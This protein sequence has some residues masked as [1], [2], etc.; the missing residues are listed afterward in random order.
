MRPG[1]ITMDQRKISE[2]TKNG[3]HRKDLGDLSQLAKS[4]EE[5]GLLHPVVIRADNVLIAGERRLEACKLLGWQKVP[6]RIV[7]LQ[8]IV[9]G[10]YDENTMRK[11]FTNSEAFAIYAE[12]KPLMQAEAK[13]RQ[14]ATQFGGNGGGNFPPPDKGKTRDKA[15]AGVGRSG[16]TMEKIETIVYAAEEM[17]LPELVEIMDN[18]SVEAAYK[19]LEKAKKKKERSE[20]AK[21]AKD[22]RPSDRWHVYNSDMQTWTSERQYDFI[23]TDPPYPREFLYLYESL[24]IRANEWLKDGGLLIAMCGQSYLD[25]IYAMMSRHIDYYWTAAYLTPG[26][27]TPLRQVN[28][29]TT[30][31]PLLI[32]SKGKYEGKIFGDV[33]RSDRNDKEFHEW[34]QSVSGMY[35]IVSKVCLPGQYILDPFCG[36]GTTGVAALK[37]E[38]FFDGVELNKENVEIS[39]ARLGDEL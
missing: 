23:V 28:V 27:P 30:W 33:F 7:D 17:G 39:R 21:K 25:E 11:D 35:D 6:V 16:K 19:E 36:A 10:E 26:Q 12:V 20:I 5:I 8:S 32:F 9:R 38:C 4:I 18:K 31:K 2:I 22:V 15:A 3:R 29:N 13:G 14:E 37:H 24:A 1:E 34:G